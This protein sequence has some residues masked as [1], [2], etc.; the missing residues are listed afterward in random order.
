VALATLKGEKA[1][2]ELAELFEVHP[3][4]FTTWKAQFLGGAA[5]ASAP[6]GQ[7]PMQAWWT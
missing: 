2:S 1:L 6:M 3:N 4:Q 7:A 5:G